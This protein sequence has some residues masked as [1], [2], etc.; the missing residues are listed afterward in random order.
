MSY[1]IVSL[2][3]SSP[4]FPCL[5]FWCPEDNGYTNFIEHAGKYTELTK[6]Y[7]DNPEH[8]FPVAESVIKD[9]MVKVLLDGVI[10]HVVLAYDWELGQL[11]IDKRR[12]LSTQKSPRYF[13]PWSNIKQLSF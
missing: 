4:D 3:H 9:I 1:Y 5:T 13:I 10:G 11:G 7:H 12:L 2:K 6:G 8:C